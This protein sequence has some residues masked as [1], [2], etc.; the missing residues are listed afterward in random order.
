MD[1]LHFCTFLFFVLNHLYMDVC[2]INSLGRYKHCLPPKQSSGLLR[3]LEC[4]VSLS[5]AKGRHAY[6]PLSRFRLFMLRVPL[7]MQ[8]FTCAGA[9]Y[10]SS[11]HPVEIEIQ[12]TNTCKSD[13]TLATS[14]TVNDR[15]SVSD[16]GV[17]CFLISSIH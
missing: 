9:V 11:L 8:P 6:C 7:V 12:R 4:R 15:L 5:E 1:V 2:I 13:G 16:P 17:F 3:A 10:S 14:V